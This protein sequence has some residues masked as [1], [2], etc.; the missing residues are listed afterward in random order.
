M[1]QL[2]PIACSEKCPEKMRGNFAR[3]P[4]VV[5]ARAGHIVRIRRSSG[6]GGSQ[7]RECV[8]TRSTAEGLLAVRIRGRCACLPADVV[9][10]EQ[11]RATM[12]YLSIA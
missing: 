6:V 3:V 12:R 8:S 7:G 9:A 11:G 5:G 10:A 2:V 4:Q 1:G